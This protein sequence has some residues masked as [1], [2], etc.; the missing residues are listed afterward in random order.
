MNNNLALNKSYISL[1]EEIKQ[2][3]QQSRLKAAIV[4]NREL[5]Q[6]YWEVGN[7]IIQKQ[8]Q[9][10]WGDKLYDNL[11]KDLIKSFPGTKGF[12]KTNLKNMKLFALNYRREQI[13]QAVP[14]QLSWTHHVVLLQSKN[15]D[16]IEIKQWYAIEAVK[17]GWSYRELKKNI[18]DDLYSRQTNTNHKTTN[19]AIQLVNSNSQFAQE[20]IKDPYKFHFLAM[21]DDAREKE[22]HQGLLKHVQEFLMELGAGFAFYGSNYPVKVSNKRYEI[23]LLMYNTKLHSYVVIELKKGEFKPEYIGQLNFYLTAIDEQLKLPE[24]NPS[25]GLLLCEHKDR[26][27]AEY[28]LKGA[29]APISVSEYQINK[30]FTSKLPYVLPTIEELEEELSKEFEEDEHVQ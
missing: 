16:Q 21:G 9:S 30:S 7:L 10:S 4:V 29:N 8:Q 23:D 12:S 19:F 2:T 1:L 3:F 18:L 27:I 26:I 5:L 24:D 25:I 11:S 22:I 28:S 20:L 6:F 13:G 17:N 14:D 15:L